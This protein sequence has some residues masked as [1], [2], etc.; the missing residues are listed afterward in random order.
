MLPRNRLTSVLFVAA[1]MDVA[2]DHEISVIFGIVL[3]IS[4]K[5]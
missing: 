1:P 3:L 5:W 2:Q 4:W